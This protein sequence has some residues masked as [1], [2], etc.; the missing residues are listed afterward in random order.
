MRRLNRSLTRVLEVVLV[1]LLAALAILTAFEL[2]AWLVARRSFAEL[3]EIQ[4]L[5]AVWFGLLAAAYCLAGRL[6]LSLELMARRLPAVWRGRIERLA[7]GLV[8]LFGALL[9][10]HAVRL[11][12]AVDNVLPATGWRASLQYVPAVA[13]GLLFV[14]FGLEQALEHSQEHSIDRADRGE[15]AEDV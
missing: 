4:G 9:A 7:S 3:E 5:L 11:V 12:A 10:V 6:H 13:A 15:P 2:V 1:G 14:L 8:A